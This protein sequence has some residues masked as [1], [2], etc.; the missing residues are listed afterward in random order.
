MENLRQNLRRM[1][2]AFPGRAPVAEMS[3][4]GVRKSRADGHVLSLVADSNFEEITGRASALGAIS[5]NVQS[6]NLRELF[7][8][9]VGTHAEYK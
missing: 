3:L 9:V 1:H 7:L 6:V 5:A 2:F 4:A 8:E